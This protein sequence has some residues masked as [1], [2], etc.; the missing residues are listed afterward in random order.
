M[1]NNAV[2]EEMML[3]ALE[4]FGR[5]LKASGK[6]WT[7]PKIRIG[8]KWH[9]LD[10]L[11]AALEHATTCDDARALNIRTNPFANT[12]EPAMT[13]TDQPEP[14]APL[15]AALD[16]ASNVLPGVILVVNINGNDQHF[17]LLKVA[18]LLPRMQLTRVK[19]VNVPTMQ[20]VRAEDWQ[21]CEFDAGQQ[22]D[23]HKITGNGQYLVVGEWSYPVEDV[24]ELLARNGGHM[25]ADYVAP[26]WYQPQSQQER[27]I[28]GLH[29]SELDAQGGQLLPDR[30][31]GVDTGLT[32]LPPD[33]GGQICESDP[34]FE[35][36]ATPEYYDARSVKSDI[37]TNEILGDGHWLTKQQR[38]V[39]T[40]FGSAN[41]VLVI[42]GLGLTLHQS[43]N[44]FL[45]VLIAMIA[46]STITVGIGAL[47]ALAVSKFAEKPLFTQYQFQ[48]QR[49][50]MTCGALIGWMIMTLVVLGFLF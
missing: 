5:C 39:L 2:S 9:H 49:I 12:Q 18:E 42:L 34:R 11:R 14:T 31:H 17:D 35:G 38:L 46:G 22:L 47:G 28:A 33:N 43:F 29:Q 4:H 21:D 24:R 6:G 23:L 8:A 36:P 27:H 50:L 10:F 25:T 16:I 37:D 44:I 19:T 45:S 48:A 41:G 3:D 13:T 1:A 15:P 32:E 7:E 40:I 20:I 26:A 30:T